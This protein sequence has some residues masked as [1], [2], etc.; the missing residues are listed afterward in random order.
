MRISV[1]NRKGLN[2]FIAKYR[3]SEEYI[4]REVQTAF[5]GFARRLI[6]RL[7]HERPNRPKWDTQDLTALINSLKSPE[8][9]ENFMDRR[10][11]KNLRKLEFPEDVHY[12]I[13]AEFR[14]LPEGALGYTGVGLVAITKIS[15]DEVDQVRMYLADLYSANTLSQVKAAVRKYEEK[16]IGQVTAGIFSPWAHYMHPKICP[17]INSKSRRMMKEFGFDWDGDYAIAIDLFM[18]LGK[19]FGIEDLGLVDRLISSTRLR[20]GLD[21]LIQ[22]NN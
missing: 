17:I 9:S 13:M 2:L 8:N 19:T 16:N 7:I 4:K 21:K 14:A 6:D 15:L 20:A 22:I 11:E 18:E 3:Q 1:L 12:L 10:F 5:C